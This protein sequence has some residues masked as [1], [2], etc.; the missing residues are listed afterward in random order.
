MATI[1]SFYF[2]P[3]VR[4]DDQM[5]NPNITPNNN[6]GVWRWQRIDVG[7]SLPYWHSKPGARQLKGPTLLCGSPTFTKLW[8]ILSFRSW[9]GGSKLYLTLMEDTRVIAFSW[10]DLYHVQC[11]VFLLDMC[12]LFSCGICHNLSSVQMCS[13]C[14]YSHKISGSGF[15]LLFSI[16]CCSGHLCTGSEPSKKSHKLISCSRV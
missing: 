5:H 11:R 6:N 1:N 2:H 7:V 9:G 16:K 10:P 14:V 15:F 3:N 4:R 12:P 8:S 13:K